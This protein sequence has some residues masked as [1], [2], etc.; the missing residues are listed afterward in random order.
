[1][2]YNTDQWLIVNYPLGAGGKFLTS[3]FFQFDNVAHWAGKPLTAAETVDWYINSLPTDSEVWPGREIDA[4][5]EL[6]N[7]SRAWPRGASTTEEEFNRD[8]KGIESLWKQ[9]YKIPDFWHKSARPAWW[10]NAQFVSIYVDDLALYKKLI[11]SKLFEFKDG[12]V[13]CHDQRPDIGRTINQA[14]KKVFQN[15]WLW[16]NIR[17]PDEFYHQHITQLP[18][19]QS[20]NFDQV[21]T[22][23]YIALS[24]LFDV[25][26]VYK[27]MLKFGEQLDRFVSKDF[28]YSMHTAWKTNTEKRINLL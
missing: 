6:P 18:W 4:P 8:M 26:L 9:G 3:C 13:I 5:W 15:Q 11:F 23:D 1:M 19:H 20:W 21:P 7:I 22:N 16:E 17:S 12:V 2:N 25:D 27:F 28:V 24:E 10:T 14:H